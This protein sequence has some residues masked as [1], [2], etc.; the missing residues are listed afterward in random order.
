MFQKWRMN[1]TDRTMQ[2]SAK[3]KRTKKQQQAQL[4]VEN[5]DVLQARVASSIG[6]YAQQHAMGLSDDLVIEE[7]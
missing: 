7:K 6:A 4:F 5:D 1:I 3:K 2:R